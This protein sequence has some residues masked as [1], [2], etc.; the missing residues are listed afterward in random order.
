VADYATMSIGS[1]VRSL[2][3][4]GTW[5]LFFSLQR[6]KMSSPKPTNPKLYAKVK[7]EIYK[8]NPKY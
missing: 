2:R 3:N 7:E 5:M 1:C 6:L 8:K 4:M